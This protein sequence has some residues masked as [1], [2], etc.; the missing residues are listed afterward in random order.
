VRAKNT[1]NPTVLL[2]SDRSD[3]SVEL[4]R[5]IGRV[6]ACRNIGLYERA[7]CAKDVAAAAAGIAPNDVDQIVCLFR[8]RS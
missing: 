7:D 6:C 5:W 2:I 3:H 4:R 1:D 8:F